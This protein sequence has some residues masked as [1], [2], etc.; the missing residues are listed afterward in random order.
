MT[1]SAYCIGG[2]HTVPVESMEWTKDGEYL[3]RDCASGCVCE[4]GRDVT[5][6]CAACFERCKATGETKPAGRSPGEWNRLMKGAGVDLRK[7]GSV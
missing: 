1:A 2:D 4:H 3:C 6:F 5:V 7:E